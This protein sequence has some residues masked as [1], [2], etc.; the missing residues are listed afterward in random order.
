MYDFGLKF[1]K[2]N[3]TINDDLYSFNDSKEKQVAII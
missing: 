3:K 1:R 2:I